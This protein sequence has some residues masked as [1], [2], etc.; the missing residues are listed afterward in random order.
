MICSGVKV[1]AIFLNGAKWHAIKVILLFMF[2]ATGHWCCNPE[3]QGSSYPALQ[4]FCMGE[5]RIIH[6]VYVFERGG[7][8]EPAIPSLGVAFDSL[9]PSRASSFKMAAVNLKI[10]Q[11]WRPIITPAL[12]AR[13]KHRA[14]I[15]G[16]PQDSPLSKRVEIW[17]EG[18]RAFNYGIVGGRTCICSRHS[19]PSFHSFRKWAPTLDRGFE[20]STPTLDKYVFESSWP[21]LVNSQLVNLPSVWMEK[22]LDS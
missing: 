3:V 15:F 10:I 1:V 2:Y 5:R 12:Q 9:H 17:R 7:E 18:G 11:R 20:P 16:D 22:L 13:L 14:Q 19:H 6:F 8:E 21:R 4:V